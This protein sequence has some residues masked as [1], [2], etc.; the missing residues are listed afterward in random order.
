LLPLIIL[1]IENQADKNKMIDIFEKYSKLMLHVAMQV[2]RNRA[3][4]EDAVSESFEKLI[5]NLHKVGDTSCYKTRSLVVI[6]VRNT[7]IN[8]WNK[9]KRAGY[10][11]DEEIARVASTAPLIADELVSEEG[12]NKLVAAINSLSD[13]YRDVAIMTFL[14]DY[15]LNEIAEIL[16]INYNTAK[17]RLSRAKKTLREKVMG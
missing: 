2:L 10:G 4:A 13:T 17:M 1:A 11:Q 6:I 3:A 15:S 16:G 12:Y 5:N 7:A 8:M 14:H 9:N